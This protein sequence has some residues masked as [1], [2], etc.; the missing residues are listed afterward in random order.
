MVRKIS[1]ILLYISLTVIALIILA[2]GFTQTPLFQRTVRSTLYTLA[3]DNL[4]A[5][6]FIGKIEGNIF[7][8]L[9]IDTIMVYVENQPLIES[10]KL[11]VQ[12]DP[13]ALL[14]QEVNIVELTLDNPSIN[15]IRGSDSVW[16]IEKFVKKK[17]TEKDTAPSPWAV[18]AKHFQLNNGTV[19]VIDSL[20]FA[21]NSF[22]FIPDSLFPPSINYSDIHLKNVNIELTG[23]YS[24]KEQEISLK[25]ISCTIPLSQ[26]D[27]DFVI[28]K[29]SGKISHTPQKTIIDNF[30]FTTAKSYLQFS[31]TLKGKD[32]FT[33]STL[34]ELKNSF[35][36]LDISPSTI[37][38]EDVQVFLPVLYFL[39]GDVLLNTSMEGTFSNININAL[40][41]ATYQNIIHANGKI[42]NLHSPQDLFLEIN[43]NRNIFYLS[44][45]KKFLPYFPIPE[46]S[47]LGKI[48][49][50][51]QYKGKPLD[52]S[53]KG[54][55]STASG[56]FDFD[57][58]MDL[59]K[60]LLTYNINLAGK[61]ANIKTFLNENAPTSNI[62]F[63]SSI[64]GEGVA[65]ENLSANMNVV[66]DSSSLNG[67]PISTLQTN[68]AA[69]KKNITGDITFRSPQGNGEFDIEM[70]F[71]QK[72]FYTIKGNVQKLNLAP[73]MKDE[74]YTSDCSFG[75]DIKTDNLVPL[76]ANLSAKIE[77]QP[78]SF[79]NDFFDSATIN[80]FQQCDSL[81]HR[82]ITLQSPIADA[83]I[84]G[85]FSFPDIFSS[86][87]NH[88]QSLKKV[89][90]NERRKF[91]TIITASTNTF[92]SSQNIF[93]FNVD[94]KIQLK[95]LEPV[96]VFFNMPLLVAEGSAEG[97]M[98]GKDSQLSSQGKISL[99]NGKYRFEDE[100]IQVKNITLTHDIKDFSTDTT[101][102]NT[103]NCD[104]QLQAEKIVLGNSTFQ[105][106]Q[107]SLFYKNK[108]A[109]FFITTVLDTIMKFDINGTTVITPK[110]Y[111][112]YFT[113]IQAKYREYEL[114]NLASVTASISEQGIKIDSSYFSHNNEQ[115]FATGT[116]NYNG[117][118]NATAQLQNFAFSSL[119]D[120][121]KSSEF[122]KS[123]K[124]FIGVMRGIT[125]L[126]GNLKNPII[127]TRLYSDNIA[128][129]ETQLG[130]TFA[131]LY[132]ANSN[133]DVII[134]IAGL[135]QPEEKKQLVFQS[136]IPMN[137]SFTSVENRFTTEGM[138]MKLLLNDFD[139]SLLD[140]FI[141]EIDNITGTL[142]GKVEANGS[143]ETPQFDGEVELQNGNFIFAMNHTN[144]KAEGKLLFEND[145]VFFKPF[146]IK[147]QEKEYLPGEVS[148]TGNIVFHGF[149]PDEFHLKA[150]GELLVLGEG[151]RRLNKVM[152]GKI[153]AATGEEGIHFEG[154]YEKAFVTGTVLIQEADITFPPLR[155][156]GSTGLQFTVGIVDDTS[157]NIV[158]T[159]A[160]EEEENSF[161]NTPSFIDRI[162]YE[163]TLRTKNSV[164]LAM[165]FNDNIATFEEL[166]AIIQGRLILRGE[167]KK[168]Q[169]I[170][171]VNVAKGSQYYFYKRFD[172]TGTLQFVGPPDNPELYILA[173]Y[174]GS[175]INPKLPVSKREE[176]VTVS[177]NITGTR[178]QPKA[179]LGLTIA[180]KDG[181]KRDYI[182]DDMQGDAIAFLLTSTSGSPG[183]FRD[184]LN[185]TEQGTLAES[186]RDVAGTYISGIFSDLMMK[187][188]RENK[189]PFVK[190]VG[191]QP[192]GDQVDV[193]VT[194]ELYGATV[195]AGGRIF[196][197]INNA[198]FTIELPMS[199]VLGNDDY[200]NLVFEVERTTVNE[201]DTYKTTK[202]KHEVRLYYR[203]IF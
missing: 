196:N 28:Q 122:R 33:L 150:N 192:V 16:N 73:I 24:E 186:A 109:D 90:E 137:L 41:I 1:K 159:S 131:S 147:N 172:A 179:E 139:M 77:F 35:V 101:L 136:S 123:A 201:L 183:K 176:K 107:V 116:L 146:F 22:S 102:L 48:E 199:T 187:F 164:R 15:I 14:Q 58:S 50:N 2:V 126:Q 97:T 193:R 132:Y 13:F 197:D 62:N 76:N 26:S 3:K 114:R 12:Y 149:V 72:P 63:T 181:K 18:F 177:L 174:E 83:D 64:K 74:Y 119:R 32:V 190:S 110:N 70:N 93:P 91:D 148:V 9:S 61:K 106:P 80:I 108:T 189:I 40:D 55:I 145:K 52:F 203:I 47:E 120:F 134:E 129:R 96:A 5:S 160:M 185:A 168:L 38:S 19:R 49:T 82:T 46:Y 121:S 141:P 140:P 191:V 68:I 67:I 94:Y 23:M 169:L 153:I 167:G 95:N 34:Q 138:K 200:R 8:G 42:K 163:I 44:D 59:T 20:S 89:Y 37:T 175:Y 11:L 152:F 21:N 113:T 100:R 105:E 178:S 170:G 98:R 194:S 25:N 128:F 87:E 143:F 51:F 166:T 39:K 118:I 202:P 142:K 54:K 157:K 156:G 65:I 165:I 78:S 31:T 151:S 182:S 195:K 111:Q 130:K 99:Q 171:S 6:V 27:K 69:H 4:N 79:Q 66:I 75:V 71:V 112:F 10:G 188:V 45:I 43:S 127:F 84:K 60:P 161:V 36:K 29:I 155:Q 56:V 135:N 198:N 162:E 103:L 173:E 154:T 88:L 133:S 180:D 125:V 124:E 7:T 144:Y 57:G 53:A 81:N 30:I 184:E 17:T 115:F 86:L 104:V 117:D 158:S 85:Q 92:T